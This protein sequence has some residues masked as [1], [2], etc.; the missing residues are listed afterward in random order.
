M[1]EWS[2]GP[3]FRQAAEGALG[4]RFSCAEGMKPAVLF[5]GDPSGRPALGQPI[6]EQQVGGG[7]LAR[8]P[9]Q[10]LQSQFEAHDLG[11]AIPPGGPE[12]LRI[13]GAPEE[14]VGLP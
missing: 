10:Y 13:P 14:P 5:P 1:N 8:Q 9:L 2:Q 7:A 4:W 11:W 6:L 12:G 3:I